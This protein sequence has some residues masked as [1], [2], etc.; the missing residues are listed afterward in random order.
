VN[1]I[2]KAVCG[3]KFKSIALSELIRG[4]EAPDD[5]LARAS[6]TDDNQ[7]WQNLAHCLSLDLACTAIPFSFSPQACLGLEVASCL[8]LFMHPFEYIVYLGL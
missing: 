2:A 5:H 7:L 8:P 4:P 1:K 6:I 3:I